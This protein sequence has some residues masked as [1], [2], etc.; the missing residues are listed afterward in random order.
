M[1]WIAISLKAAVAAATAMIPK[2]QTL[3]QCHDFCKA[4]SEFVLAA[5]YMWLARINVSGKVLI[6]P[7]KLMKSPRNGN[8]AD[9]KVVM[10][11]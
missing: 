5:K 9:T 1:E 6:A 11:M 8:A 10:P 3:N 7:V 2:K 4:L